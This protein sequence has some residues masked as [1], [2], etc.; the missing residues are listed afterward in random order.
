MTRTWFC[1]EGAE[2]ARVLRVQLP[3]ADDDVRDR[4]TRQLRAAILSLDVGHVAR[5]PQE[6][7]PQGAKGADPG[8]VGALLVSLGAAGG[9][10]SMVVGTIR[11]WL[12]RHTD[13]QKVSVTIA[14]DTLILDR[15][16]APEREEIIEAFLRRHEVGK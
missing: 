7:A 16:S 8:D 11:D 14:G 1:G 9:L 15:A 5:A 4:W 6:E 12:N 2:E 10:L 13:A 3:A